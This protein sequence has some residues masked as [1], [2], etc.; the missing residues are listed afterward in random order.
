M[1]SPTIG[2]AYPVGADRHKLQLECYGH[3]API[4][5]EAGTDTSGI[6][7]YPPALVRPLAN[8][9]TACLY[10]RIGTGSSDPPTAERR[11]ID[12]SVADLDALLT[13]ATVR[14]PYVLVGQSGG[15]NL[16]I[17]YAVRHT[18]NVRALVLIDVGF[19]DPDEIAKE[20][21][22]A[23]A[24]A[25]NEHIDYVDGARLEAKIRMPIATFPV[26]IIT[27]DHG[28]A[29]PPPPS[30][31]RNLTSDTREIVKHGGHDLHQEIPAEIATEIASFLSQI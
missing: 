19:D 28:E 31:W 4:V 9:N 11:T 12:D 25:G 30:G 29:S 16:A 13:A 2:G 26:L 1:S 10:D 14:P 5:F 3:G 24:W 22:G 18:N 17:W 23:L 15:G 27:A 20:F 7:A 21:P 8:T 6:Q